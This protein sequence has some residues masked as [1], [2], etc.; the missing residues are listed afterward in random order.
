M[1]IVDNRGPYYYNFSRPEY[2][3]HV[4]QHIG[5]AV[6]LEFPLQFSMHLS[7]KRSYA[8]F[9]HA[10]EAIIPI[11][12]HVKIFEISRDRAAKMNMLSLAVSCARY[13]FCLM[14][15]LSCL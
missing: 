6:K 2:A 12:S 3:L 4:S 11:V 14:L 7:H 10:M 9:P 8:T 15:V 5:D 13:L 1:P